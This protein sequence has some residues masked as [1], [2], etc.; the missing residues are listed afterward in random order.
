M[1][2]ALLAVALLVLV[3]ALGWLSPLALLAVGAV[4]A[5]A[6]LLGSLGVG[7]VYHRRLQVAAARR[8]ALR[9]GWWWAPSRLHSQLDDAGRRSVLPLF[10]VGVAVVA[11]AVVGCLLVA[12]AA[13]K[14]WLVSA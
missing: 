8:G 6:G 1:V 10:W 9:P 7:V 4:L 13:A 2:E 12:L 5:G 14:A 3:T 11:L